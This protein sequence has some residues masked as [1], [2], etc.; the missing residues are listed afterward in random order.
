MR[1]FPSPRRN[2]RFLAACMAIA[3]AAALLAVA[4]VSHR[5]REAAVGEDSTPSSTS[6]SSTSSE[7]T[8]ALEPGAIPAPLPRT[9][10]PADY[11][12]AVAVALFSVDPSALSRDA[13][14]QFWRGELP[15]VVYSDAAADGLTLETQNYDA[16]DNLVQGWI[17]SQ[18][19]WNQVARR[20]VTSALTITSV[21]VP[22]FWATA[23]ASGQFTD[24]GLRMERVLGIVSQTDSTSGQSA[25]T[26]RP[27]VI[28]LG[29]LCA[30][31]QPDGCRL[32]AP[33]KPSAAGVAGAR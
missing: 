23:V 11:A 31:T 13:F 24:P 21:S 7:G 19:A 6:P 12:S 20:R 9:I 3:S 4:L 5:H 22:D 16:I 25:T 8:A 1:S 33:Q 30:P 10:S 32:L 14:L 2:R 18:E 29:L 27:I 17:P 28:D 26:S 15:T